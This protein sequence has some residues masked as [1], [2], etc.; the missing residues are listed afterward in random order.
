MNLRAITHLDISSPPC[1][2]CIRGDSAVGCGGRLEWGGWQTMAVDEVRDQNFLWTN[3]NIT[4]KTSLPWTSHLIFSSSA[5]RRC[6]RQAAGVGSGGGWPWGRW[7]TMPWWRGGATRG[8][9][10]SC[11][12][13]NFSFVLKNSLSCQW[14]DSWR[15]FFLFER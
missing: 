7:R 4:P 8:E 3:Q 15:F 10:T 12:C 2:R 14:I 6:I 9:S 5:N 1:R 13:L 11:G